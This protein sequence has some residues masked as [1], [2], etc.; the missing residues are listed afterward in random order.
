MAGGHHAIKTQGIKTQPTAP[1]VSK[2]GKGHISLLQVALFFKRDF[3]VMSTLFVC[4]S[5]AFERTY[6]H[7]PCEPRAV[8][9]T[10]GYPP[11]GLVWPD[12]ANIIGESL[13]HCTVFRFILWVSCLLV[14]TASV[15]CKCARLKL[16][17]GAVSPYERESDREGV[18]V[19]VCVFFENLIT[20]FKK[21]DNCIYMVMVNTLNCYL[22]SQV[23]HSHNRLSINLLSYT[24]GN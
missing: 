3:M 7:R 23:Y 9:W 22:S 24:K 17:G 10:C 5:T 6:F 18:C 15:E 20:A 11:I 2:S 14:C 4:V 1:L 8:W 12:L 19:C 13:F 16:I 21:R